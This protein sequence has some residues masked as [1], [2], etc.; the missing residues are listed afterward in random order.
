MQILSLERADRCRNHTID[1]LFLGCTPHDEKC[2]PAGERSEDAII[3]CMVLANQLQ[4]MYGQLKE[5]NQFFIC[6]QNHDFGQ[7]YELCIFYA[8]ELDENHDTHESEDYAMNCETLPEHW[9]ELALT[10]LRELGHPKY[11]P[12]KVIRLKTA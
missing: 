1:F 3:E 2:T 10:E 7:Y 4:R 12:A 5:S 11:Q 6:R 8:Q 9:D